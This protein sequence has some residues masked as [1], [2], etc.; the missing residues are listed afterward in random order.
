MIQFLFAGKNYV[1]PV[2]E[3]LTGGPRKSKVLDLGTGGGH[4]YIYV[5]SDVTEALM[6]SN[7]FTGPS[8]W[9]TSSRTLK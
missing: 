4:W 8:I 1:G 7:F 5:Q 9:Q 3:I 2:K 6:S